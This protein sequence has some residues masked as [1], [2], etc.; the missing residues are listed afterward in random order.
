M[1]RFNISSAV[2]MMAA[3]AGIGFADVAGA[4]N[5]KQGNNGKVLNIIEGS[6]RNS[7]ENPIVQPQDP[8]QSGGGRDQSLQFGD[9]LLGSNRDDLM[10]G[11]LGIDVMSGNR[12]SDVMIGG[13]EDFNPFNRDRAFGGRGKDIFMWAPGDGSDLFDGGRGKDVVMFGLIGEQDESG[14]LVFRVDLPGVSDDAQDFDPIFIDDRTNLPV[15]NVNGS[16][17]FCEVLDE[18]TS[19]EVAEEALGLDHLVRFF[20]R[21]QAENGDQ[22]GDNGLRVTLHL[23]DVEIL[24][25]TNRVGGETEITDLTQSPPT[26]IQLDDIRNRKLQNRLR[27]ILFEETSSD[28]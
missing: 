21:A 17:G 4:T 12:G 13:T 19:P 2:V 18:S 11:R 5:G 14:N 9:V 25:C 15:M 8:A 10:I 6:D 22:D 24:V 7:S 28:S 3:M 27:A 20:I 26:Q 16:P 1:I 23:K